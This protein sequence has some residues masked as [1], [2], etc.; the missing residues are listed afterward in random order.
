MEALNRCVEADGRIVAFEP[1]YNDITYWF[2]TSYL[3][4]LRRLVDRSKNVTSVPSFITAYWR[5]PVNVRNAPLH[6]DERESD[7]RDLD[8]LRTEIKAVNFQVAHLRP[9]AP[10]DDLPNYRRLLEIAH[11]IDAMVIKYGERLYDG[12]M[13]PGIPDGDPPWWP[14]VEGWI[15]AIPR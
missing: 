12:G 10:I 4:S 15:R 11:A 1:L 9:E 5:R 13:M 2:S 14:F 7:R 3:M 6:I 8:L